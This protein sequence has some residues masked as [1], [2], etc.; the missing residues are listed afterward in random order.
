MRSIIEEARVH[1]TSSAPALHLCRN[2]YACNV[3]TQPFCFSHLKRITRFNLRASAMAMPAAV[4]AVLPA[5]LPPPAVPAVAPLVPPPAVLVAA[6]LIPPLPAVPM[7]VPLLPP[8]PLPAPLPDWLLPEDDTKQQM[9]FLVSLS[10]ILPETLAAAALA[11]APPLRDV[12]LLTRQQV[13]D[14]VA[15]AV[16]HPAVCGGRGRPRVNVLEVK[17]IAV[18][19]ER[20]ADGRYHFHVAVKLTGLSFFRPFKTAL[21][22]RSGLA[23]HWSPTHTQLWSAVRYGAVVSERKPVVDDEPLSLCM[24]S[25]EP[26]NLYEE[27][28]EPYNAGA[29]KR[30]REQKEM[31]EDPQEHKGHFRQLDLTSIILTSN[32]KSPMDVMEYAQHKGSVQMQV[33][34]HKNQRRLD[35][36]I[37]DAENWGKADVEAA[38]HRETDWALIQRVAQGPCQCSGFCKWRM[39]ADQFFTNNQTTIDGEHFCACLAKVI[40]EGPSKHARVPLVAGATNCAKSTLLEPVDH[41]F[42]EQN[43]AHT[44]ALGSTMAL[45]NLHKSKHKRFLFFDEFRPVEYA[46]TPASSPTIPVLTFLKLFGGQHLEVQVSQKFYDGNAD[47][48][49]RRG[50]AITSKL[51][52]LW[53][54]AGRVTA[55]DV[56]HMQ[57]RVHMFVATHQLTR[58]RAVPACKESFA[59]VLLEKAS[60][61]ATRRV[62][63]P[64]EDVSDEEDDALA[65]AVLPLRRG[66][67]VAGILA[68]VRAPGMAPATAASSSSASSGQGGQWL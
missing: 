63:Q 17:K 13:L 21:R 18:F 33:F 35:M 30:R 10:A 22:L 45:A 12:Q 39:A 28:Q 47:I 20:H 58:M 27:S 41:V 7:V 60:A 25:G 31:T 59:K 40:R 36:M 1:A 48:K 34:V 68:S 49:W 67:P 8:P 57:Q 37:E 61:F 3:C 38:A 65:S 52:G 46:A 32:L 64:Q 29:W 44:P 54:L 62:L 43:V 11:G 9:V 55:E 42:G 2:T 51:D 19:R 23:S 4:P 16:Q 5:V 66:G 15:D 14:A 50:A 24:A 56:R 6:P 26:L 53:D